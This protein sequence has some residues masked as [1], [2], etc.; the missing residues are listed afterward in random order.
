MWTMHHFE[1][2][3]AWF[4]LYFQVEVPVGMSTSYFKTF[5]QNKL[6]ADTASK[7]TSTSQAQLEATLL[8]E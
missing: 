1:S 3:P 7:F 8:T 4:F 5:L 6:I 2:D